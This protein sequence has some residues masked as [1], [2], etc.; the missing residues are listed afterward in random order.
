[1]RAFVFLLLIAILSAGAIANE[2]RI[3]AKLTVA[4]S[5][6]PP[7]YTITFSDKKS[8][9]SGFEVDIDN[10]ISEITGIQ[11]EYKIC[12]WAKCV[13]WLK[14]GQVDMA[15]A[16]VK[17]KEREAYLRF[18][19]NNYASINAYRTVYFYVSKAGSV[20]LKD[21]TDLRNP[22]YLVG[23]IRG[24]N[25]FPAFDED[26]AINKYLVA[27]VRDG[28]DLLRKQRLDVLALLE[29]P[30]TWLPEEYQTSVEIASFKHQQE[31]RLHRAF[32]RR[33]KGLAY[34]RMIEQAMT[35]LD[36]DGFINALLD[37]YCKQA[38]CRT[39]EDSDR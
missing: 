26:T 25:H 10:A 2:N 20:T 17:N 6:F 38:S 18:S 37:K 23:V 21:Y 16:I 30:P 28:L 27:D 5:D 35:Q 4:V 14:T 3:D 39:R 29:T 24:D 36:Q 12:P 22:N 33:G 19:S 31:A 11:F 13:Q 1:M 8:E 9:V 32:S 7:Y 15:A 34:Q